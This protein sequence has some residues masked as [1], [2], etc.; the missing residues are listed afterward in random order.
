MILTI[1]AYLSNHTVQCGSQSVRKSELA[2]AVS[3][4]QPLMDQHID[5][6]SNKLYIVSGINS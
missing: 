6:S 1:G 3:V 2:V 5:F 4:G